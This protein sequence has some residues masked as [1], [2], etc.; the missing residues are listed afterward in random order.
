MTKE[1]CVR[2]EDSSQKT[3]GAEYEYALAMVSY[4]FWIALLYKN[5]CF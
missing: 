4:L 5:S 3:E 1:V 2:T